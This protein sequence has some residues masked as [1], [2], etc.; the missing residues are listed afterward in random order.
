MED[1][2]NA[3]LTLQQMCQ[4]IVGIARTCGIEIVREV[5]PVEYKQFLK[6]REAAIAEYQEKLRLAKESKML[7]TN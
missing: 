1:P 3:L 6:D 4:M 2:P 7:R 5:D